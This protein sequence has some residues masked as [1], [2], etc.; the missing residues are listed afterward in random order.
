M[1]G[2]MVKSAQR[3]FEILELFESECRPL[4]VGDIVD[5]LGMPQSSVS[6]LLRTL[7]ARGYMEFDA[8]RREYCPSVR[9]SFLGDWVVRIPGQREDIQDMLRHLAEETGETVLMG[10]QNG[11]LMQY[12]SMIESQHAL[13]LILPPGTM[14]PLH[15]S[16]IGIMLLSR[17]DDERIGRLLRRFNAEAGAILPRANLAETM[18]HV[19][20]ARSQGYFESDSLS[21]AGSG[22]IAALLSRPIRG[23]Q[24]AV[25]VGGP[26]PRLHERRARLVAAV[27]AA[28][29]AC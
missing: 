15:R 6:M 8:A 1:E 16:A 28:G 7:V 21:T 22:V 18:R 11:M 24:L 10:R 26:V 29:R 25:G 19:E 23:Q 27:K 12:V 3:V 17:M 9:V 5:R 4:R 14:R 20:L 13:R 2:G